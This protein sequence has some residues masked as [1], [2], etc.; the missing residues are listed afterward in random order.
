[1]ALL[2]ANIDRVLFHSS[3]YHAAS[4]ADILGALDNYRKTLS[5]KDQV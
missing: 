2:Q 5:N 3:F 1:M 4:W